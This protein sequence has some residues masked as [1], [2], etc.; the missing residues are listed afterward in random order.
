MTG[1]PPSALLL[2]SFLK[3]GGVVNKRKLCVR[4]WRMP[5]AIQMSR[6]VCVWLSDGVATT[7]YVQLRGE[8]KEKRNLILKFWC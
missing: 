7:Y 2:L 5:E 4:V 6:L 8:R 1:A 3:V